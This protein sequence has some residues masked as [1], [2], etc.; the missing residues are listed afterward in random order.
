MAL[1]RIFKTRKEA[2]W[3][4]KILSEGG[5]EAEIVEDK[6]NNVPIQE[7]GVRARFRVIVDD[8]D[9]NRAAMY[10]AGKLRKRI[11]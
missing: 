6:F 2:L 5:I 1:I 10:F 4:K 9:Y 11:S 3:A 8:L 7:F